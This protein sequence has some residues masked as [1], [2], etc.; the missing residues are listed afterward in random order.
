M[1]GKRK[2]VV[3]KMAMGCLLHEIKLNLCLFSLHVAT[4][5]NH[6]ITYT[7]GF[8]IDREIQGVCKNYSRTK[9]HFQGAV[10]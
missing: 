10:N 8:M 6:L 5:W 7:T 4:L 9:K 3:V 2:D 1:S